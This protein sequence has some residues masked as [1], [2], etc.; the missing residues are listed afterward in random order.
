M[1]D[2]WDSVLP[3]EAGESDVRN[4]G[5]PRE[6]VVVRRSEPGDHTAGY[7]A[8]SWALPP[9]S[10]PPLFV[11]APVSGSHRRRVLKRVAVVTL[12]VVLTG[13]AVSGWLVARDQ[14]QV[15]GRWKAA[16]LAALA[17]DQKLTSDLAVARSEITGLNGTVGT[18]NGEVA[19]LD[20]QLSSIRQSLSSAEGQ[21]SAVANEK[22]KIQDQNSVLDALV[23]A[24]G[25]VS[26]RLQTCVSESDS[27]W[28]ELVTDMQ[29]GSVG[30][31]PLL[32]GN[33]NQTESDCQAAEDA[34]Q[35]LQSVITT[36][37]GQ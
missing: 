24:A 31:D 29:D 22:A 17:T 4:D 14:G 25:T 34:N 26:N 30:A 7:P 18:L 8:V 9:A 5:T 37:T 3:A 15:A 23:Q 19:S 33:V 35:N 20:N 28:S 1:S 11:P 2:G 27:T 12:L 21:L 32:P 10:P 13:A 16:D 36:T 6:Q